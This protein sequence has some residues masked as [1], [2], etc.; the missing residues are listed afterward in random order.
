MSNQIQNLNQDSEQNYHQPSK[1]ELFSLTT[2]KALLVVLIV[3]ALGTIIIGGGVIIM[4]YCNS[5]INNKI[6]EQVNQEKN[7]YDFLEKK[8]AGDNCCVSSLKTMRKNNYKKADENGKCSEGFF[9]NMTKCITSY[10]WCEPIEENNII[11]NYFNDIMSMCAQNCNRYYIGSYELIN[12]LKD[13]NYNKQEILFAS[14]DMVKIMELPTI[15]GPDSHKRIYP[16][17][18]EVVKFKIDNYKKIDFPKISISEKELMNYLENKNAEFNFKFN[19]PLDKELKFKI[20][21]DDFK[22][23]N[24][25]QD[26]VLKPNE[27]KD[28]KYIY[29]K[30]N[31]S[32]NNRNEYDILDLVIINDFVDEYNY[33]KYYWDEANDLNSSGIMIYIDKSIRLED[34]KENNTSDQNANIA[35]IIQEDKKIEYLADFEFENLPN[36]VFPE[37]KGETYKLEN[38][39]FQFIRQPNLNTPLSISNS[40]IKYKGVLYSK[41]NGLSWSDLFI[42]DNPINYN[43]DEVKYN[44]VGMFVNN[45]K[46]YLDISDDRGAGS[47]EGNLLRYYTEDGEIWTR[48][49]CLYLIPENYFINKMNGSNGIDPFS[50]I[51]NSDCVYSPISLCDDEPFGTGI[52]GSIYPIDLKYK[53]IHF[54]GQLFTAAN[55]GQERLSQIEG[56]DGN[57]YTL[58]S[59]II[60]KNSPSQELVDI[61][62]SIGFSCHDKFPDNKC[63]WWN[64]DNLIE[65][66][67]LLKLEPH[68]N[69][70]RSDDCVNCG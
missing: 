50:L 37:Q 38:Y 42:I 23:Y 33:K 24:D 1:K 44:P 68:H 12:E 60:L 32:R 14:G 66:S 45:N 5:E 18:V 36:Y 52:G 19:N 62:K 51:A 55:C 11:G 64:F 17:K 31:N 26:V 4:K 20:K 35:D 27:I 9:M 21:V 46:L 58:G 22:G 39:I 6:T 7:Y 30:N 43:G 48:D 34:C 2:V 29:K 10:Q 69:N 67:E 15:A 57:N 56:V 47:G 3:V 53:N 41:D 65:I 63:K 54:L 8:C 40:D 61:F 49:T 70:F 59:T 16:D 25:F 13:I 28:I